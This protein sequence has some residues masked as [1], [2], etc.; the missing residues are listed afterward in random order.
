LISAI[1]VI[2][3]FQDHAPNDAA[4]NAMKS[5]INCGLSTH[6]IPSY[7]V[8][9]GHRDVGQTACPG[10]KLYDLIQSWPHYHHWEQ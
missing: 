6:K 2:G 5:L 4:L 8:L 9:K 3:N 10:Q 1:C 7:Y